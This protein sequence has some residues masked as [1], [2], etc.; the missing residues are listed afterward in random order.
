MPITYEEA[1]GTLNSMFGA[2][3]TQAHLDSVLRHF[4]GHM[5]NT[6]EAVLAHGGGDPDAL[7]TTL[8]LGALDSTNANNT[9]ESDERL[10]Q[11]L[12]MES[13]E[14]SRKPT[15]LN[16]FPASTRPKATNTNVSSSTTLKNRPGCIGTPTELPTDF[17]RIPSN[18]SNGGG[19][20]SSSLEADEAL[21]R[22]LQDDLFT[23]ELANNPQ[24]A[25]LAKGRMPNASTP[26]RQNGNVR[27]STVPMPDGPNVLDKL[28]EMGENAKRSLILFA[29]NWNERNKGAPTGASIGQTES[30]G[31]L[32][33]GAEDSEVETYEMKSIGGVQGKKRD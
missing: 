28:S 23:E 27:T 18:M 24:F 31:L 17:L 2:P 7:I 22:M 10:A 11:E 19:A 32:S 20:V 5:E 15:D 9:Y 3:W 4:E 13:M 30:R 29:R 12:S 16:G 21:A 8:N 6:V 33:S 1:L 25:H 14:D 26:W